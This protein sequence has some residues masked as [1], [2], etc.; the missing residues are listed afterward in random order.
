MLD[1]LLFLFLILFLLLFYVWLYL[2]CIRC[3]SVF[4]PQGRSSW[5][6][7]EASPGH[8]RENSR[9]AGLKHLSELLLTT[10]DFRSF[11]TAILSLMLNDG[12]VVFIQAPDRGLH[13]FP[14]VLP[15]SY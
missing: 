1:I 3:F 8:D 10:R 15:S 11:L 9:R 14:A 12:C 7:K 6:P 2:A 13:L 4:I 5:W